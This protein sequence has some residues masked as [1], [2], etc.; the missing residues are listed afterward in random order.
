MKSMTVKTISI[1][2][3]CYNESGNL[4]RMHQRVAA[5]FEKLSYEYELIFVDNASTDHSC[6]IYQKLV[7]ANKQVKVILMSRNFGNSQPSFFAGLCNATGDAVVLLDGDLQDPP[8]LITQFIECWEA[9]N[10]VVYGVRIKRSE[11]IVRRIGY[12]GFYKI[13]KWLSYLDIPLQA[14]DFG[15]LDRKVVDIIKALPEKDLYLRGL[16]A[17]AGF[18]QVGVPYTR[19]ERAEGKTS[20]SF[21]ANF[22]WAKKAI[23]NFS[24]KPL[25]YISRVAVGAVAF[26]IVMM[27]VYLY[28]AFNG[29]SPRG[30][31]TLFMVL[32]IFST[33]QLL[34]LS[35]LAEY[36]LRIFQEVKARPPYVIDKILSQTDEEK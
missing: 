18:K 14:G 34:T 8:E 19:Q 9:G 16:R 35:I 20:N 24:T 1:I 22:Y 21:F 15:L 7:N 6:E 12:W 13:F 11:N 33:L 2:V 32:C 10:P 17:W 29:D 27:M 25:E 3:A 4:E 26:T 30:F 5:V 31:L 23:V 28:L 36:L